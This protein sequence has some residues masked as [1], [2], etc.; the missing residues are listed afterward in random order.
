M[1]LA[2]LL[3]FSATVPQAVAQEAPWKAGAAKIVITPD[4]ALLMS[5]Y[6]GRTKPAEG[7]E[8]ELWAKA[9]A[10]EDAR[11]KKTVLVTLDRVGIGRDLSLALCKRIQEKYGLPRESIILSCSHTHCGPVVGDNLRAM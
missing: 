2:I 4:K 6:G 9:L 10:L 3:A 11:G 1:R 5:G 7:K 8:T